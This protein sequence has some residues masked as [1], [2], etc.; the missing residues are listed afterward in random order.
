M[1]RVTRGA[2]WVMAAKPPISTNCT[3][4]RPSRRTTASGSKSGA[5]STSSLG[6]K[7]LEVVAGAAGGHD[8]VLRRLRQRRADQ[9][10][11]DSLTDTWLES[12]RHAH[13]GQQALERVDADS[14]SSALD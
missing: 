8:P 14:D 4:C 9:A 10:A 11:V 12:Q 13:S 2:P 1:S 5:A 3:P 6:K 7:R